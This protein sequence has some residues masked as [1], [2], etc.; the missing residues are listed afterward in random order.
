MTITVNSGLLVEGLIQPTD[1]TTWAD[2]GDS[3]FGTWAS[4][5]S[6]HP[7]PN[8]ISITVDEDYGSIDFRTPLIDYQIEG[9]ATVE[10]K[11]SDTGSFAGEE[12]TISVT[13]TSV[14]YTS[15]RYY[16][17]NI[18]VET[19]SA[20]LVPV[21]SEPR[22]NFTL[23]SFDEVIEN[24]DTSTLAED[25]IGNKVLETDIGLVT[26]IVATAQ[27]EGTTYSSGLLQDRM[28]AIPDDYV[29]QENAIIV[30]IVDKNTPSIR[31]FDL[32]GESI[33]AVIDVL[34]RGLPKI[35]IGLNGVEVVR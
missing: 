30:N 7:E 31:C 2:L 35:I 13:D 6:Y 22:T 5:T 33:D 17:W 23:E 1:N 24:V 28:Y 25:S 29:F 12:T 3:L 16:R 4:W 27:Q 26:A 14:G 32:N 34:I 18:T 21:I 11:I 10:L 8:T 20:T 9:T 19:D 15:G